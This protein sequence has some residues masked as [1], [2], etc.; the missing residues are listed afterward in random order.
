MFPK[1]IDVTWITSPHGTVGIV[2]TENDLGERRLRASSV[3]G[4]NEDRDA[5]YVAEWGGAVS[6]NDL[7]RMIKLVKQNEKKS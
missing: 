5:Q 2:V 6:I 1:V 7:E 3:E 4:E